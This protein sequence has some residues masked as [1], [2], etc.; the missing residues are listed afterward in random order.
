MIDRCQ[1][2]WSERYLLNRAISPGP[3]GRKGL[4]LLIGA[5]KKKTDGV[6]CC[7]VCAKA[8]FHSVSVR[9]F[10]T[11]SYLGVDAA[12]AIREHGSALDEAYNAGKILA[13]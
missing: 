12:G 8:F 4:L 10:K 9:D 7:E 3:A 2:F 5:Y 1:A 13:A 11:L 6:K